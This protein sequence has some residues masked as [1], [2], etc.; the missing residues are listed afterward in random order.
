[1]RL[2][3]V[4]VRESKIRLHYRLTLAVYRDIAITISRRYFSNTRPFPHNV[5]EDGTE[6]IADDEENEDTIDDEQWIRYIADLQAAHTTYMAE[7]VYSRMI[8]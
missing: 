4:L 1:V 3:E 7:I 6:V 8:S 2:K 5:R